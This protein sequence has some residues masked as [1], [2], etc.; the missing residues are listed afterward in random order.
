MSQRY[1]VGNSVQNSSI[2]DERTTHISTRETPILEAVLPEW[3]SECS[4]LTAA[5]LL[6]FSHLYIRVTTPWSWYNEHQCIFPYGRTS[7]RFTHLHASLPALPAIDQVSKRTTYLQQ[8]DT[9]LLW[10]A[11]RECR[12]QY[13]GWISVM[14]LLRNLNETWMR[15]SANS[16]SWKS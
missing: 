3:G 1:V 6:D 14:I 10:L 12:I 2:T 16:R 4:F 15:I 9:L 8:N 13:C 5:Y 11:H 7:R